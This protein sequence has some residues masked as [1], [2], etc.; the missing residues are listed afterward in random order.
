MD[1]GTHLTP[2]A[3]EGEKGE[4]NDANPVPNPESV[5]PI[6]ARAHAECTNKNAAQL[7]CCCANYL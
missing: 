5:K 7:Q 6:L 3:E 4:D 2:R 1:D